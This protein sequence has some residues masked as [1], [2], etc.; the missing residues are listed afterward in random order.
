MEIIFFRIGL[1]EMIVTGEWDDPPAT[2]TDE[3]M[4]V[5]AVAE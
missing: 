2:R 1:P 5:G 3:M 4:V